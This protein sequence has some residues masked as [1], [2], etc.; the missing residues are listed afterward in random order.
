[1]GMRLLI[2]ALC[3]TAFGAPPGAQA[4]YITEGLAKA[5]RAMS[6]FA[7]V[8]GPPSLGQIGRF[9]E[10]QIL[11]AAIDAIVPTLPFLRISP[12]LDFSRLTRC[13]RAD[14][15]KCLYYG[16]TRFN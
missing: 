11:P 12:S 1:M 9:W 13:K 4:G 5:A 10:A 2:V 3:L 6:S 16:T 15:H 14:V 8:Y 7:D